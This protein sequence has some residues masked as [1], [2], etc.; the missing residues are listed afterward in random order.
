VVVEDHNGPRR[1]LSER[2]DQELDLEVVAQARSLGEARYQASS[3]DCDMAVVDLGLPDRNGAD[4]IAEL[5]ELCSGYAVLILSASI[6]P[7]SLARASE[8]GA[9]KIMGKLA[10]L[11]EIVDAITR[12]GKG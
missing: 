2:I 10:D 6:N 12:L 3:H 7:T 11:E 8:A 4:L 9:D 1:L 5:R